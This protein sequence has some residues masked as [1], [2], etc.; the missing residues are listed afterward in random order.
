MSGRQSVWS[1]LAV[2][3]IS[4]GLTIALMIAAMLVGPVIQ[5]VIVRMAVVSL[6]IFLTVLFLRYFALLWFAYLGHAERNVL[7]RLAVTE[8]G[9]YEV[10]FESV[11]GSGEKAIPTSELK[12]SRQGEPVAFFTSP[13]PN[14]FDKKSKLY[15][16]SEGESLNRYGEEAVYELELSQGG[17]Q[18]E[19]VDGTP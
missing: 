9:L 19:A 3:V 5:A 13:N 4:V 2:V 10:S 7:A 15:F 6:I 1:G 14:R 17:I 12:L 8:P 16:L 11:F 18:M